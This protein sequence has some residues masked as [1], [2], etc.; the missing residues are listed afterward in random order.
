MGR[1]TP[2]LMTTYGS[3]PYCQ[4]WKK[5]KKE[6][7]IPSLW[8]TKKL[9]RSQALIF[10]TTPKL[11]KGEYVSYKFI[12]TT[13]SCIGYKLLYLGLFKKV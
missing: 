3:L 9:I 8:N 5:W 6:E 11:Q 1:T 7:L 4:T 13:T 12:W 10:T 2:L